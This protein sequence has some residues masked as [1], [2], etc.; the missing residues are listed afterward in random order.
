MGIFDSIFGGEDQDQKSKSSSSSE[1]SKEE[2]AD[3]GTVKKSA[4]Q[5]EASSTQEQTQTQQSFTFTP[6]QMATLDALINKAA[7][8]ETIYGGDTQDLA[9]TAKNV[10]QFMANQLQSQPNVDELVLNAKNA[11]KLD[12]EENTAP[13]LTRFADAVGSEANSGVQLMRQKAGTDLATKLMGVEGDIRL[14]SQA[15]NA[16]VGGITSAALAETLKGQQSTDLGASAALQ[17]TLAA[18]GIAK[19]G[20]VTTVGQGVTSGVSSQ[21]TSE[22]EISEQMVKALT[23]IK[24]KEN[25]SSSGSGSSSGSALNLIDVLL[26]S[27][28]GAS[29]YGSPA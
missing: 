27:F 26:S 4:G 10:S 14:K 28:A 20:S 2:S 7:A 29:S 13:G 5:T 9:S 11:A 22:N 19:G 24:S 17:D 23:S 16:Q 6:E 18:L 12:F 15:Q 8:K 25:S 21:Q 1:T 3:T